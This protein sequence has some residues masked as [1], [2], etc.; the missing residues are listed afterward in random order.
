LVL[1]SDSEDDDGDKR[2]SLLL[3]ST[4]KKPKVESFESLT[5]K[6]L[7][8]SHS[9]KRTLKFLTEADELYSNRVLP[10]E[11]MEP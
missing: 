11:D 1:N 5:Q 10:Y 2:Y 3:S 6:A 8:A 9:P 4:N 7:G